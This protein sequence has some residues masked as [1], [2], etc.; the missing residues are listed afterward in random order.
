MNTEEIKRSFGFG[1]RESPDIYNKFLEELGYYRKHAATDS[2]SLFR[3]ISELQYDIQ[4]YHQKVRLECVKFMRR[5]RGIFVKDIKYAYESYVN[6]LLRPRTYGG[7][8]ELKALALRYRANIFLFEPLTEGKWFVYNPKYKVTW[9]LF[10]GRD[11]HF[12]AVYPLETIKVAAECQAI[13]YQLL[14]TKVLGLPDVEYSVERMLHDPEDKFFRYATQTD[15]TTTAITPDGLHMQLSKPEDTNC[16]LMYPHLC[17]FHNEHYFF[18]IRDYFEQYGLEEGCRAYIGDY[19][20]DRRNK[21]N[22]LLTDSKSS[23]VRQLLALGITPF[24][25]KVAKA[26]DPCIYRNVEYDVWQEMRTERNNAILE[27]EKRIQNEMNGEKSVYSRAL[28]PA[29]SYKQKSPQLN[30]N[31]VAHQNTDGCTAL[32]PVQHLDICGRINSPYEHFAPYQNLYIPPPSE[33]YAVNT[34]LMNTENTDGAVAALQPVQHL[35]YFGR[36]DTPFEYFTPYQ[37]FYMPPPSEHYA[38]SNVGMLTSDLHNLTLSDNGAHPIGVHGCVY[39]PYSPT[40]PPLQLIHATTQSPLKHFP[41][42]PTLTTNEPLAITDRITLIPNQLSPSISNT[43]VMVVD[44]PLQA[45]QQPTYHHQVPQQTHYNQQPQ[46]SYQHQRQ[47]Q[48]QR[49][50]NRHR[51]DRQQHQQQ[52]QEPRKIHVAIPYN[53]GCYVQYFPI[54]GDTN[55]ISALSSGHDSNS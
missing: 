21:P 53:S 25:Y 41:Q 15:G 52:Q 54:A 31:Y 4:L 46:H 3:V 13:V 22:P 23:C 51:E 6:N 43:R 20:Q 8:V 42:T 30:A 12:D 44:S 45:Q 24:P 50:R 17:H 9:R 36:I 39:A 38:A 34:T 28:L 16:V 29:E 26:L 7:M 48:R 37:S 18:I 11:N 32:E 2:T 10:V 49:H 1:C 55:N 14:Y 35:D 47:R 19:L 27:N 5:N 33:P 40:T